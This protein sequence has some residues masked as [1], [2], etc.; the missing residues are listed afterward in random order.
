VVEI[1]PGVD[2]EHDVLGQ[3]GIP[4]RVSADLAPMDPR[5]F[6]PEPMALEL[7][8]PRALGRRP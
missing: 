3:A 8:P 4:L 6:R 7:A 2:L 5:L 1:A